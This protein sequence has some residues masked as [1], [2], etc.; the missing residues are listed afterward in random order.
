MG[1]PT[2]IMSRRS[3]K[4]CTC[5]SGVKAAHPDG[6]R[7]GLPRGHPPRRAGDDACRRACGPG[8]RADRLPVF[9]GPDLAAERGPGGDV[10]Q[11]PPR[12]SSRSRRRADPVERIAFAAGYF[13]R[14]VLSYQGAV[15]AMISATI[16]RPELAAH[17]RVSAA[18]RAGD[19]RPCWITPISLSYSATGSASCSA[20]TV[21]VMSSRPSQSAR[22]VPGVR[23]STV[24]YRSS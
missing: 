7:R 4:Y 3:R 6:D 18:Y 13:L 20:C 22:H 11:A 19:R 15:R 12:R 9:P 17:S 14:R 1:C 24:A 23:P 16:T 10:G 8:V 2:A 5:K 21:A